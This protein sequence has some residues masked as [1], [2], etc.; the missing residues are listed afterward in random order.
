M[1]RLFGSAG[2]GQAISKLF[3]AREDAAH[4]NGHQGGRLSRTAAL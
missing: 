1:A 3:K 2:Q 4:I